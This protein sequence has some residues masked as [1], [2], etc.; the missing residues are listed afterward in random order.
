M[1]ISHE[2]PVDLLQDSLKFNDYDYALLHLMHI[3]EYKKFYINSVKNGRDVYLDCSA[4]EY[5]FIEGGFNLSYYIDTINELQPTHVI[6]PDVIADSKGTIENVVNFPFDKI[7]YNPK[8]IGVVQ[9]KTFEELNNCFEYMN[10]EPKIDVIA[11]V[12]HS[13]AYQIDSENP[14]DF[15]NQVGRYTFFEMIQDKLNK[16][17]HLLGSSCAAEF[18]MYSTEQRTYIL[19]IDTA[20][21]IQYALLSE[22]IDFKRKPKYVLNEENIQYKIKDKKLVNSNIKKF[23][24]AL[25]L[26]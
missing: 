9:G 16:P 2:C 6:L 21:P 7:K 8:Y 12:F 13:P 24:E 19:S 18:Q 3:P 26:L 10:N 22:D 11:L 20:C 5:Q 4:Y 23:R 15:E 17:I 14:V 25:G 1:K